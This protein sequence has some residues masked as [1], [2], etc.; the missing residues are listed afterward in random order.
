MPE[1]EKLVFDGILSKEFHDD[2]VIM[3]K[4]RRT[5]KIPLLVKVSNII[6]S[7]SNWTV[8]PYLLG[9]SLVIFLCGLVPFVGAMLIAYIKAPRRGLQAQHRYF[10]LR[11]MSQQ[12]IRVH[13]KTK[14]PEYIGFGLVANL[15][16]SIPLFNL[17][18]IFTDTIGAAL[19]VVKIESERKLNMLKEELNK[20]VRSD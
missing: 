3:G 7:L 16:E 10:F 12:Q 9:R 4:V 13:Y 18:F 19:W 15:L 2:V 8:L 11:G 1:I 5:H 14:K 17:L 6:L 20:E